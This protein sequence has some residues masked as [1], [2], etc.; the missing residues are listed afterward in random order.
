[1]SRVIY[2]I[3]NSFVRSYSPLTFYA[4]VQRFRLT[5]LVNTNYGNG[6]R[7]YGQGSEPSQ[8]YLYEPLQ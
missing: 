3:N 2:N 1:M 4:F 6:T 7:K 8:A 5:S